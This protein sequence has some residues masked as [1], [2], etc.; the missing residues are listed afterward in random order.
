MD[1]VN[2]G[3]GVVASKEALTTVRQFFLKL[4]GPTA[5]QFGLMGGDWARAWR[6]KNLLAI[7]EKCDR[8]FQ[9]KGI[10]PAEGRH[11]SL[12]AGL[13]LLEKASYHDNDFLQERW[14]HLITSSLRSEDQAESSFNLDITCVEILNQLSQLDCEVLEF[15]VENSV[16]GNGDDGITVR[17]LE[18]DEIQDAHPNTPSHISLEKLT[19]LGCARF[20]PKIPL[21]T[22]G[23][24][25]IEVVTPTAIGINLYIA[26]SGK[27]P[28]GMKSKDG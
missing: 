23:Q 6:I 1:D 24:G 10:N 7:N 5:E 20:D 12:A 4:L 16:K 28:K 19:S 27:T 17:P 3:L 11:L 14:A 22:G 25:L 26:A 13:P 2:T 8:I 9:E 18:Q 15:I 21:K